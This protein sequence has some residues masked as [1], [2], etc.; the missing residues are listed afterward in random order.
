MSLRISRRRVRLAAMPRAQVGGILDE[1]LQLGLSPGAFVAQ[2]GLVAAGGD[3]VEEN[4]GPT[5]SVVL[6]VS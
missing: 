4:V 6:G 3:V 5:R 1:R 2:G